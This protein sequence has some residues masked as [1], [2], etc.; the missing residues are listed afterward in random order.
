MK[1]ENIDTIKKLESLP[2]IV[3]IFSAEEIKNILELYNSL[4]VTVRNKKQ[5]IIKKRWIQNIIN[6]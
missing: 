5:N 3:K 4:P 1:R 6:L 2:R